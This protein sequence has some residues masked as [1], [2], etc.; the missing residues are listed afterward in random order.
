[1]KADADPRWQAV[2]KWLRSEAVVHREMEPFI[3]MLNAAIVTQGG[4]TGYLR[5]GRK[6]DG[7][8]TFLADTNEGA[9]AV[10]LAYLEDPPA[11]V[12]RGAATGEGGAS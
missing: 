3:E 9:T 1:M 12:D 7:D 6:D 10:A 8:V 5:F 4:P 2:G 11:E